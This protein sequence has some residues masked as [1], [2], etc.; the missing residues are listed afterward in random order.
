MIRSAVSAILMSSFFICGLRA[1]DAAP[2]DTF[3]A[4]G[5]V[6]SGLTYVLPAE[7]ELNDSMRA[8]RLAKKKMDDDTKVR[9][10]IETQIRNVKGQMG[11]WDFQRRNLDALLDQDK[12]ANS[13]NQLIANI[14]ILTSQINEGVE[15]KTDLE[16][17]LKELGEDSRDKYANL[18]VDTQAKV[19]KA[20]QDYTDVNADADV[21]AAI[22]KANAA[23]KA[24]VR[25]G[26]TAEFTANSN[27]L[28][29]LKGDVAS[30]VIPIKTEGHVP[31]VDVTLNGKFTH[32]MVLDS[33]A[34]YVGITAATAERLGLVP[35]EKDPTI[36]LQLAD[37]KVVEA[38]KMMLKSVRVGQFTVEAVE[39]AVLPKS[40]VAAEDLLGGTFLHN[41]IYKLDPEAGEL[42]LTQIKKDGPAKPK[43]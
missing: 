17:K 9:V 41:F 33:G 7:Q 6:K 28:K 35:G 27:Q 8:I 25:L 30:A 18:V 37:G 32:S 5:L 23:G 31:M 3:K 1:E 12:D 16:K 26:P 13:N 20:I 38:K 36:Q 11:Q 42:H 24:K 39:C 2:D 29:R 34:S 19:E 43:E 22:E 40:L 4:K 15:A 14:N 10:D 21:K